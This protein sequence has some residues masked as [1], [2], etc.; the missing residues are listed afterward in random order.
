LDTP[1]TDGISTT[2]IKV[3][4]IKNYDEYV[5]GIIMKG[6]MPQDLNIKIPKWFAVKLKLIIQKV[7]ERKRSRE[8]DFRK[9]KFNLM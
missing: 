7:E 3:R 4:I 2:D 9:L 1:R 6:M 8:M 5:E